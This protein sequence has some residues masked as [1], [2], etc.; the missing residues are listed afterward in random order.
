MQEV[1][2]FC[3]E[4]VYQIGLMFD[5][6]VFINFFG[7]DVSFLDIMLGTLFISM[8]ITVFWKGARG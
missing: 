5:S 7:Y 1:F 2:M 4:K 3:F 8:A 6:I